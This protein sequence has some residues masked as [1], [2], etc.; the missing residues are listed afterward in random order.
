MGPRV[1]ALAL[2]LGGAL[3]AL[4]YVFWTAN[5][6]APDALAA[7]AP[8]SLLGTLLVAGVG[9]GALLLT[10]GLPSL[11]AQQRRQAGSL[12]S[13]GGWLVLV[14]FLVWAV[15]VLA[16][17]TVVA[18]PPWVLDADQ[19]VLAIGSVL[20]GLVSLDAGVLPGRAAL[21]V[22][23]AAVVGLIPTA[24]PDVLALGA[25]GEVFAGP[26]ALRVLGYAAL[27]VFGLAW[28]WLGYAIYEP[29]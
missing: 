12:G 28:A 26:T 15:S 21:L 19:I 24:V 16:G 17:P 27:V 23:V 11:M 13:V 22:A 3:V 18:L 10:L 1:A 5:G 8:T 25:G 2:M 9:V 6:V 20:F 14:G 7:P 29:S 4:T